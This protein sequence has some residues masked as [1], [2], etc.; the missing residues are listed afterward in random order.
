[1]PPVMMTK[2]MPSATIARNAELVAMLERLSPVANES[3]LNEAMSETS[4]ST[5]RAPCCWTRALSRSARE[6]PTGSVSSAA[7]SL[8]V[9]TAVV[10]VLV[11][12]I[13][14]P[15]PVRRR[16]RTRS[17]WPG[18]SASRRAADRA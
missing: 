8:A 14:S 16:P 10:S 13:A 5:A 7:V 11:T 18:R 12:V 6:E 17:L 4:T 3:K 1:M 2:V 9:V 15:V